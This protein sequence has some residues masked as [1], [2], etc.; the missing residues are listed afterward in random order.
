MTDYKTCTKCCQAKP[1]GEYSRD[2]QRKDGRYPHCNDC[3]KKKTT[4]WISQNKNWLS[5]YH[6]DYYKTHKKEAKVYKI[7]NRKH[8]A[9]YMRKW[10]KDHSS[11]I[12]S[13]KKCYHRDVESKQIEYRILHSLRGRLLQALNGVVKTK[14]T[15]K[16]V[17][18]NMDQL[19]M[20]LSSQFKDGM[21][22]NN[23]GRKGW[24]IDHITSCASFDLTN[25]NEQKKCFHYTNL[26]PL[27]WLDN[28]KKNKY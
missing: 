26:Q 3:Q 7:K 28:C 9:A 6:R 15:M 14:H 1:I 19:R 24:H 10:R 16:F 25:P 4:Q 13:Y 12:K 21:T 2:K 27:W 22:W 20:H 11:H 23:Y 17:G 8:F 5:E 18:C